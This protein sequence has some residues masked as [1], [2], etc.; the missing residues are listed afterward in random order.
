[1]KD[2]CSVEEN[3]EFTFNDVFPVS[4]PEYFNYGFDVIDKIARRSRNRLAMIWATS[5]ERKN[6]SPSMTF[7]T[8]PT[9]R[10]TS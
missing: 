8:Y 4:V 5:R 7:P 1:M 9:G 10:P 3:T 6:G 2:K